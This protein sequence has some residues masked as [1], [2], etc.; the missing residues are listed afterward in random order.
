MIRS[1]SRYLIGICSPV[2][3][4]FLLSTVAPAEFS[5][6]ACHLL[7]S[8]EVD[9][10][11]HVPVDHGNPRVNTEFVS[12]CSFPSGRSGTVSILI[13]R[14]ASKEW[15]AEQRQRMKGPGSFRPVS[16]VGDSAFVLDRRKDG[17][18]MCVFHGAY[19]LQVSVFRLGDGQS[20]L[21][22]VEVLVRKALSRLP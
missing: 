15:I 22:A 21:P 3:L 7:T 11:L 5:P 20:V 2:S 8:V 6:T 14:N 16:V 1:R 10:A 12:V 19:Y 4:S 17:A 13:R 18:A 9:K